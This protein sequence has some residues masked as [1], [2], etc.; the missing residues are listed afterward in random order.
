MPKNTAFL[1][2]ITMFS[3]LVHENRAYFLLAAL[4]HCC[5]RIVVDNIRCFLILFNI[6]D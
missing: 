1:D 5:V 3:I 6:S 2:Y 4:K